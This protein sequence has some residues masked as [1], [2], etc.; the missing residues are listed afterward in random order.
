MGTRRSNKDRNGKI[1]KPS[2][3]GQQNTDLHNMRGVS[4]SQ[5]FADLLTQTG[6][7]TINNAHLTLSIIHPHR[8]RSVKSVHIPLANQPAIHKVIRDI[9]DKNRAGYGAFIAM[10]YR[11]PNL[12]K[13]QRGSNTDLLALPALYVDIDQPLEIA[14][15]QLKE[16]PEPNIIISTGGGAHA[17]W[18]L[19]KPLTDLKLATRLIDGLTNWTNGDPAITINQSMRL[20]G[21]INTKPERHQHHCHVIH[22]QPERYQLNTLMPFAATPTESNPSTIYGNKI[23][24][25]V[26]LDELHRRIMALYDGQPARTGVWH[27][28]LCPHPDRHKKDRPGAHAQWNPIDGIVY[29]HGRHGVISTPELCNIVGIRMNDYGGLYKKNG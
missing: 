4:L 3:N 21:S 6:Q 27:P 15:Q 9:H 5:A 29:C 10:A 18:L 19:D 23:K 8:R 16:V 26:L 1:L 11:P 14:R 2:T 12:S 24:N 13:F 7:K 17:Y 28:I 25:P 22:W 20:P